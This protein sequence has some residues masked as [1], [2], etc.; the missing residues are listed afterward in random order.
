MYHVES[1]GL[2]QMLPLGSQLWDGKFLEICWLT[3]FAGENAYKIHLAKKK[4]SWPRQS[5]SE[6]GDFNVMFL[7]LPGCVQPM[8]L[9]N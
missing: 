2:Y 7:F 1:P 3:N 6:R 9:V 8:L 4:E 5:R